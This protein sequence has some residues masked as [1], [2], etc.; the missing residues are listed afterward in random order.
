MKPCAY[1]NISLYQYTSDALNLMRSLFISKGYHKYVARVTG[2]RENE[3]ADG[4]LFSTLLHDIGKSLKIYQDNFDSRCKCVV[5]CNFP[6][7]EIYSA[8]SSLPYIIKYFPDSRIYVLASILGHESGFITYLLNQEKFKEAKRRLKSKEVLDINGVINLAKKEL[9]FVIDKI[10]IGL[11]D[12]R[13]LEHFLYI[14]LAEEGIN[15]SKF[16]SLYSLYIYPI[17]I[18]NKIKKLN[19]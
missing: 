6:L 18:I 3:V 16:M 12:I 5:N 2:F 15:K 17:S 19:V 11:S 13:N 7:H 4:L 9:G 1:N 14:W 8:S 10:S